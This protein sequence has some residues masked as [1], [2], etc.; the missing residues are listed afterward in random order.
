[1]T[2]C[3]SSSPLD[4]VRAL[5]P[6]IAE[7]AE[8]GE[9]TRKL[10]LSLVDAIAK[11]GLFRLLIPRA[12]GGEEVDAMTFVEVIEAISRVDGATGWCVM[13]GGCYGVFGG[14]LPA[15]AAREIYG[16]DE[17]VIS[18][19]TFRPFGRAVV[20][21]GGYRVSGRWPLGSGCHHCTWMVGNSVIFDG[22]QPKQ[23]TD[24]TPVTRL[25]FFPASD[26]E[27]IDTWH[28]AGLR[29][30]GSNDYAVADLFVPSDHSLSFREPPVQ[31]GALYA[32]P[33]LGLFAAA[34]AA[35][36][37]GIAR[38]AVDIFS[39]LARVKVAARSR[40][41]LNQHA[42]LQADLGRAEALVRS[43]RAFLYETV[44]EAWKMASSGQSLS[45]VQRAML[46]LAAT[47][48][49]SAATQAVD[50][51]FSAGGSSSVYA[52]TGLERCL[53]DIRTAAQHIV[54][55]PS[56]Y[57]MVGQALLGLDVR[58]T[59]MLAMDDRSSS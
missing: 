39:E 51:M 10:P 20:A 37:L 18:G 54:V 24:G 40:Q 27:I 22:E 52:S 49:T 8:E 15:Q 21:D 2:A 14:Y 1:M 46:W 31:Q 9:R 58:A 32:L 23:R 35:V 28:S 42:M 19:G 3:S 38:H 45:V 30:T 7:H 36:P 33:T 57:E 25:L 48:A 47:H 34:I 29:A 5:A 59:P 12:L 4:A 41:T 11:A 50:L 6:R 56:N 53:R 26:C 16:S 17:R 43:G 13:I 55:V 44:G